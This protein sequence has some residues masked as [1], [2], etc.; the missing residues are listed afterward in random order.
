[1]RNPSTLDGRSGDCALPPSIG[2]TRIAAAPGSGR[3]PIARTRTLALAT[4]TALALGACGDKPG[5]AAKAAPA[6]TELLAHETEL[7]RVT[8]SPDAERRLGVRWVRVGAVVIQGEQTVQGE[9]VAA[10]LA[11]GLPLA[12]SGDLAVVAANQ[13]RADGDV[14]RARAELEVAQKAFARADAL[15]REEAGSV[16]ARDEADAA[17]GVARATLSAAEAQ[18]AQLGPAV[19]RL[20]TSR[21]LWVRAAVFSADA[22]G[23][24][25]K[26]PAQVRDLAAGAQ[27]SLAA[28]VAGPPGANAAAGTVDI[29]YALPTSTPLRIGQRVAVDLPTGRRMSGLTTPAAAILRDIYGGEWVYV[30]TADR[31]FE[32]RRIEVAGLQGASAL[33]SRGLSSG[34]DVVTDGAAEL[35]GVEF[36]AK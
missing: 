20:G 23:V 33:V 31:T 24:D 13:A 26:A 29:F 11:G 27:T 32:R 9:V 5:V 18:R 16:R 19:A 14:A 35:F 1:M 8:L 25:R 30:R 36:G 7:L 22:A 6:K 28:P 2:A 15:V 4:A 21:A 3:Q 34:D 12:A 10:P 17:R